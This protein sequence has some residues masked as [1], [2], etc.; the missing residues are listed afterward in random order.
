LRLEVPSKTWWRIDT[1]HPDE[2]DWAPYPKPRGRFDPLSGRFRV[3][4]AANRAAVAARERFVSKTLTDPDGDHWLVELTAMPRSLH[5][6]REA[7]LGALK[8]DDR[9]ST[10]RINVAT[11]LHAHPLLETC[12]QLADAVFDWWDAR[13]PPLVYRARTAPSVGRTIAFTE[14]AEPTILRAHRLREAKVLHAHLV[15]QA[16]FSV[17]P[18]WL[19]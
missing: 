7:N 15:L 12:G 14:P 8:L 6:T 9:V 19:T 1:A 17:P 13:P 2:W 3:R 18:A 16:G 11:R 4:Y 5:L 10:G